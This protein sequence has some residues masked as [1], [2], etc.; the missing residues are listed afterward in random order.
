MSDLVEALSM[1]AT[2]EMVGG[3]QEVSQEGGAAGGG[4][5]LSGVFTLGVRGG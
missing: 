4:G 3:L 1:R 2:Q 5:G